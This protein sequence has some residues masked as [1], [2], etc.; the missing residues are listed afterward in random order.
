MSHSRTLSNV[1]SLHR[2]W[3]YD[4]RLCHKSMK[5]PFQLADV[6]VL[7]STVTNQRRRFIWTPVVCVCCCWPIPC[8]L[9]YRCWSVCCL[10]CSIRPWCTCDIENPKP[11]GDDT[12]D[13]RRA[14][15]THS[16]RALCCSVG[17]ASE[18]NCERQMIHGDSGWT[19]MSILTVLDALTH[20]H[21]RR[22]S[23]GKARQKK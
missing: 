3:S 14:T 11:H 12:M 1:I 2:T 19:K 22:I 6:M 9:P 8:I 4:K 5:R 20:I 16:L 10:H 21:N 17:G 18:K 13:K 23:S 15:H 7:V